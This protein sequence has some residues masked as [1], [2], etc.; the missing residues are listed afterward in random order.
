MH[1][2]MANEGFEAPR[3]AQ[4]PTPSARPRQ[5]S[6]SSGQPAA[7]RQQHLSSNEPAA[8]VPELSHGYISDKLALLLRA[9]RQVGRWLFVK[10]QPV[11]AATSSP[12]MTFSERPL[13]PATA[14]A[15]AAPSSPLPEHQSAP[16]APEPAGPLGSLAAQVHHHEPAERLHTPLSTTAKLRNAVVSTVEHALD[17][18]AA[19]QSSLGGALAEELSK[20]RHEGHEAQLHPH[21]LPPA[22]AAAAAA[23]GGPPGG[24]SSSAGSTPGGMALGGPQQ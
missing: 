20:F 11:G 15:K 2:F 13:E 8:E 6:S 3:P 14:G 21:H 5:L 24:S 19:V 23:A 17:E 18:A 22:A 12:K 4:I 9:L 1:I 10:E 16:E 7:D